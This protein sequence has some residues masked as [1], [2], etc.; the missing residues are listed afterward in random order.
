MST[1]TY[2]IGTYPRLTTTFIDREI[3]GLRDQGVD[4]DIVSLRRPDDVLSPGQQALEEKVTYVLPAR[5]LAVAGSHIF[6]LARSPIR[7]FTIALHLATRPHR[8]MQQRWRTILHFGL[9]VH[10]AALLRHARSRHLHAHFVDRAA[11]VAWV[12]GRLLDAPYSATAHANDIYVD[13]VLL[14]NKVANAKF[15]ATCTSF[16]HHH[17]AGLGRV[18]TI[19]HGLDFEKY[20]PQPSNK[21]QPPVI[22]AVGQ[23]REKKGFR[24]LL[25]ACRW[26]LDHG[27][28]FK[29]VIVGEGPQRTELE[30]LRRKLSLEDVAE[31]QGSLPHE[32]VID[33][34][35]DATLFVLPCLQGADGDRDGIPNVILEAMAMELPVVSTNHSGIPEAIEDGTTGLLVP[36]ADSD[37]LAMAIAS[38]LDDPE[39][40]KVLGKAA[41]QAA[42]QMFDLSQNLS[43]L[44]AEL[45]RDDA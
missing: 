26:L 15:V 2:I 11:L 33:H 36:P 27:Y 31:L 35:H 10:V 4:L 6:W 39:W 42:Q 19:R 24:H 38:L 3:E 40:A 34:Y 44:T 32:A 18:V 30:D 20:R 23:L 8:T 5:P 29:C 21:S 41:R 37:A 13:P 22:L 43:L 12:A 9:A 17:L 7:Y 28:S 45:E 25:E 14:P 16:N 1:L